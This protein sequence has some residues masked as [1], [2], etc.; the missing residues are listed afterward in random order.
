MTTKTAD[1]IAAEIAA[2]IE[3]LQTILKA[4]TSGRR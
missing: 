3:R 4:L 1:Q 2:E